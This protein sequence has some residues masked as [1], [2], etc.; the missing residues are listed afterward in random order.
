MTDLRNA[1]GAPEPTSA[2][3]PFTDVIAGKYYY[4]AVLWAVE[5]KITGG[6]T[7]TQFGVGRTCTRAQI[8]TFLYKAFGPK[9]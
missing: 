9:D 4:K 5:N 3:N 1:C 7:A 2:D 8:V 6:V